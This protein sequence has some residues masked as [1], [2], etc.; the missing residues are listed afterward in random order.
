MNDMPTAVINT[1]KRGAFR[2]RRYAR[3]SIEALT[4]APKA[5]AIT[6]VAARPPTIASVDDAASRLKIET[7]NVL[8]TRPLSAKTSPWA[9]LISC[10]IP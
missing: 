6:N 5:A 8:E 1:D 7:M 9:K 10:R 2:K 4:V 3:N